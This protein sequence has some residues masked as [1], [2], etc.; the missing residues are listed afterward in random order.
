MIPLHTRAV[1]DACRTA[2]ALLETE[3]GAFLCATCAGS[4]TEFELNPIPSDVPM[5]D[6]CASLAVPAPVLA[7]EATNSRIPRDTR[8]RA[9]GPG[10]S[11]VTGMSDDRSNA[12]G[13]HEDL[14]PLAL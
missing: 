1:C 10:P 4:F 6:G 5:S 3:F 8:D 2:P 9:R 12:G 13:E 11:S 7:G 14:A